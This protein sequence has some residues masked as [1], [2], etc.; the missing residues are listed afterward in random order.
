MYSFY[1]ISTPHLRFHQMLFF[2]KLIFIYIFKDVKLFLMV[3]FLDLFLFIFDNLHLYRVILFIYSANCLW[4]VW[5]DLLK[6]ICF[7]NIFI[8]LDPLCLHIPRILSLKLVAIRLL[9]LMFKPICLFF[10]FWHQLSQLLLL[11][12]Q[13][14]H[15]F[16]Q[17]LLISLLKLQ[18]Q[19]QFL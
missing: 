7:F 10:F 9:S 3:F 15:F 6:I 8:Y 17:H 5:W 13:L 2:V 4:N 16:I 18:V 11:Q 19:F 12:Y 1:T 14:H